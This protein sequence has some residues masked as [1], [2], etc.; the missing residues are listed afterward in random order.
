MAETPQ[1]KSRTNNMKYLAVVGILVI[2]VVAGFFYESY[3]SQKPATKLQTAKTI[4]PA[5]TSVPGAYKD[6][7]YSAEGDYMTHVGQK[8]IKVTVTLKNN[9]ITSSDVVNEA[10]DIISTIYQNAFIGGYKQYVV[11]KD[12]STVH[13]TKISSSSLTPYGFNSALQLIEQQAKA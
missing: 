5:V 10:D 6:G 8:H 1:K 13:L 7:T 9:M 11:G 4:T 12:I 2:L 3:A